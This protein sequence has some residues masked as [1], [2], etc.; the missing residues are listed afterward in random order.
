MS[1]VFGICLPNVYLRALYF[2]I[3]GNLHSLGINGFTKLNGSAPK[4]EWIIVR[5]PLKRVLRFTGRS[6][7]D[8]VNSPIVKN[9]VLGY[10][11]LQ[12]FITRG[13]EIVELEKQW[14]AV[15]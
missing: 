6:I 15:G 10:F 3:M 2:Q 1:W 12:K 14:N 11:K 9:E 13:M 5:E 7:D 4:T 8:V